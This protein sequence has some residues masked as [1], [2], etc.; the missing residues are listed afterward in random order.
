[1]VTFKLVKTSTIVCCIC[2]RTSEGLKAI[3]TPDENSLKLS[4]K[5]NFVAPKLDWSDIFSICPEC[6]EQLDNAY[7]FKLLCLKN[8][9]SRMAF[10]KSSLDDQLD[11]A[12]QAEHLP[13]GEESE[14]KDIGLKPLQALEL[15]CPHCRKTFKSQRTLETHFKKQHDKTCQLCEQ[16]F[17]TNKELLRHKKAEHHRQQES[18]KFQCEICG[19]KFALLKHILQHSMQ[20]HLMNRKDIK[21]YWCD[22]CSNK[23]SSSTLLIQHKKYHNGERTFIC[24]TCGKSF[25]TKRDLSGH[26]KLHDNERKYSC[27]KCPK[28]FN[29]SQ[30]L[31]THIYVVHTDPSKWKYS[32]SVC[33]KKFPMKSNC[34]EHIKRHEGSK[35]FECHICGKT[36]IS[37]YEVKKHVKLHSNIAFYKCAGCLKHYRD[38]RS[39]DS[40]LYKIHGLGTKKPPIR[41]KKFVCHI[42]PSQFFDNQK[43]QR[44]IRA[45]TGV[46]PFRCLECDKRFID[47]NYL[48]SHLKNVHGFEVKTAGI[49]D[50][51]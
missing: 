32:C 33:G 2:F 11:D 20:V 42:C 46:K 47:K 48:S 36:F 7:N 27:D 37:N 41:V 49:D 43:L 51:F 12:F 26:E 50:Y 39:L 9:S 18:S 1:M 35:D 40:H 15:T 34:N 17:S 21:P 10:D 13:F 16:S 31:K 45:H 19:E 24:T 38:K 44:H 4:A 8:E 28:N 30:N 25:V 6:N 5:L 14:I 23:F 22:Q 3:N 29:T